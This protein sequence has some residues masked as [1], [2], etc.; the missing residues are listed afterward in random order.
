MA[1]GLS[2]RFQSLPILAA[3]AFGLF[4]FFTLLGYIYDRFKKIEYK[5]ATKGEQL[6]KK[7][8]VEGAQVDNKLEST[9]QGDLTSEQLEHLINAIGTVEDSK[10]ESILITLSNSCAFTQNQVKGIGKNY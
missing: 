3:T 9:P 8:V 7:T 4:G 6:H 1:P 5:D 10:L 2:G